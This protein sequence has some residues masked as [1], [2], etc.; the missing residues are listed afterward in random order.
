MGLGLGSLVNRSAGAGELGGLS[1][2]AFIAPGLLAAT[3]MQTGASEGMWP[4]MAGIKWIKTYH[5]TLA[6]PIR[7]VDLISGNLM[8]VGLRVMM[9]CT[10]FAAVSM[11]FGALPIGRG[12]LALLPALLTG[13][14]F[15][16]PVTAYTASLKDETRLSAL[17]RFGIIP[18][19]LFSGTF[20]PIQQL[21]EVL[22]PVAMVT[23]LWHGVELCRAIALG[24]SPELPAPLHVAY[25]L[26]LSG[27]GFVLAIRFLRKRLQP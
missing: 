12:V 16:A 4:V 27:I 10:A 18:M 24:R 8:W 23:P 9:A 15:A 22:R 19:F 1:Y 20:F 25:L 6:T 3:A 7:V 17:M 26:V 11:V 14:A 5:A 21:P 2:V 13:L